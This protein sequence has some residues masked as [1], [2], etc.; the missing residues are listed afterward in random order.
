MNRLKLSRMMLIT[1]FICSL[2]YALSYPY[3]YAEMMKVV[4]SRYISAE[5]IIQCSGII[6]LGVLW[7]KKG[8]WLYKHFRVLIIAEIIVDAIMFSHV[9]I[10]ENLKA[11]FLMN[12]IFY[13]FISRHIANG[14]I[15]LRAKVH[16]DEKSR[17]RYDNN[18]NIANSAA[19]LVGAGFAMICPMSITLLFIAA[20]IGNTFDNFCYWYIYIK[21]NKIVAEEAQKGN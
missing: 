1:N 19:T 3:I 12:V 7:N 14:G 8:D 11:Y 15:R 21:I 20:L 2:F 4:S 18:C 6:L 16:P 10:T 17:E 13:A 9:L 5:Q